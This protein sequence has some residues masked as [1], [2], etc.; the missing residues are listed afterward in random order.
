M[1]ATTY[2]TKR[3][4]QI[5][6]KAKDNAKTPLELK[7]EQVINLIKVRVR[8]RSIEEA[9][10]SVRL[11]VL[12]LRQ[13]MI[14]FFA[15]N[16]VKTTQYSEG[17]NSYKAGESKL[18]QYKTLKEEVDEVLTAQDKIFMAIAEKFGFEQFGQA[19]DESQNELASLQNSNP[20][21][22]Q[23]WIEKSID[24]EFS[25]ITADLIIDGELTLP[26]SKIKQLITF[27]DRAISSYGGFS[28]LFKLWEPTYEE[29]DD[30]RLT[31]N[32][33]IMAGVYS[34]KYNTGVKIRMTIEEM[35]AY[36][37]SEV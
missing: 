35:K 16:D 10:E 20:E 27:M 30:S 1:V 32:M 28:I 31:M 25:L 15:Q 26:K 2:S 11:H 5:A 7:V 36:L 24:V 21:S 37:L 9:A 34:S 18:D 23:R 4:L 17:L 19:V 33:H 22:L 3:V 14:E 6:H 29:I 12:D 8:E 13:S